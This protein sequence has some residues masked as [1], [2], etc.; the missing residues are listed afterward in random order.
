MDATL[1]RRAMQLAGTAAFA[2]LPS[3]TI[4]RLAGAATESVVNA[5]EVIFARGSAASGMYLIVSG[6]LMLSMQSPRGTEHVIEFMH[7]GD[8]FGEDALITRRPHQV[9]ATAVIACALLHIEGRAVSAAIERDAEFAKRMISSLGDRLYRQ[10]GELE[11]MLFLRASGR[12]ARFI[13]DRLT[14]GR[15]DIRHHVL[16][17]VRKGLIASHLNMTQEHF[18][19]T[20][21]ELTHAGV[22]T[23]DGVNVDVIDLDRLRELASVSAKGVEVEAAE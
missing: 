17:P 19:R 13:L 10:T 5:G 21:H 11:N 18:S 1:K 14:V 20:L 3:I 6:Q 16:L 7:E 9:T 22:I 8:T 23:V 12:L 4:E 15:G 2:R